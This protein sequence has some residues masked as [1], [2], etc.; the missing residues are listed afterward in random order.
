MEYNHWEE[1]LRE[2]LDGSEKDP[3]VVAEVLNYLVELGVEECVLSMVGY[4]GSC[5]I[6]D[7]VCLSRLFRGTVGD[8][9]ARTKRPSEGG[10]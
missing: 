10:G 9:G 8:K 1:K 3:V 4:F 7:F 6:A 5:F 2:V